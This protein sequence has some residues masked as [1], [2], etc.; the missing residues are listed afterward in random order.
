MI[1]KTEITE[2]LNEFRKIGCIVKTFNSHHKMSRGAVGFVDHVIIGKGK[3]IFI[4]VKIGKDVLIKSQ[5]EP[6]GALQFVSN[7]APNAVFYFQMTD[8]NYEQLIS[9][10]LESLR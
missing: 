9:G 8:K 4:E 2:K 7:N 3:I 5:E 6:A 1:T 10:L